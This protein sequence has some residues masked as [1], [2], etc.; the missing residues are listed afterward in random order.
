MNGLPQESFRRLLPLLLPFLALWVLFWVVPL[1]LGVDLA[2][3]N[4]DSGFAISE[5]R[6]IEY[7]GLENFERT[8]GLSLIHI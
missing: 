8:L 3:Q 4:P 5:N 2:L 7:V 1:F 6:E